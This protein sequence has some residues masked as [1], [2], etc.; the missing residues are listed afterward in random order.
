M[1]VK[2]KQIWTVFSSD[3]KQL[4]YKMLLGALNLLEIMQT[5]CFREDI[6]WGFL[7]ISP[8]PRLLMLVKYRS[9]IYCDLMPFL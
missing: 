8:D 9:T 2:V 7:N 6:H 1:N 4:L 5:K 3:L